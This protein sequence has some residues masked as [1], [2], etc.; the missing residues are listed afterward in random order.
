MSMLADAWVAQNVTVEVV[1]FEKKE[2]D[3]YFLDPRVERIEL[4]LANV[5]RNIINAS[6]WN[7]RRIIV[8]RNFIK[9]SNPSYVVSFLT[10]VNIVTILASIG[11]SIPVIVSERTHPPRMQLSYIWRI[12]RR[13]TYPLASKVVMLSSDGLKWLNDEIPN[14]KGI[15]IPNPVIYPLSSIAPFLKTEIFDKSNYKLLLGVGRLDDGKQFDQLIFA[16]GILCDEFPNWNLVVLGDGVNRDSLLRLIIKMNLT[17]RVQLP[18]RAGNIGQWYERADLFVMT[19]RFEGFP[20]ALIEAMAYGCAVISY[21][22]DT[23]P[24][25]L[26]SNGVDGLLIN[27]VGDVNQLV[28]ALRELMSD[29]IRREQMAIKAKEVQSRYSLEKILD[30]WKSSAFEIFDQ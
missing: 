2:K 28:S 9:N 4:N 26:I 7:L 1:T 3:C 30:L 10:G 17:E 21:D 11:L 15:V 8:L 5:S 23:G 27:P 18:G 25:D 19:S 24:R 13:L 22:C 6:I 20:N 14:A 12:L 29:D 16:F